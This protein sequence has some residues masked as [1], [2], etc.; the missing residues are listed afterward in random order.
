M[1][2][3]SIFL[4]LFLVVT[5]CSE[6]PGPSPITFQKKGNLYENAYFNFSVQ[7][8]DGWYSRDAK[9]SI[10]LQNHKLIPTENI[11]EAEMNKFVHEAMSKTLPLF[12][13]FEFRHGSKIQINPSAL[14]VAQNMKN[15]PGAKNA[16]DYLQYVMSVLNKGELRYLF[17]PKCESAMINGREYSLVKAYS[18]VGN[19]KVYQT[20][21]A[22]IAGEHAISIILTYFDEETKKKVE[23][24]IS[25]LKF[26]G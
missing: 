8:P 26:K 13:F 15:F 20:Y 1:K 16:C 17:D 14:S 7:K 10:F 11:N 24:V 9:E 22:T 4:I 3:F 21:Y 12:S 23:S 18:K 6:K 2:N 25:S 19:D 5:G